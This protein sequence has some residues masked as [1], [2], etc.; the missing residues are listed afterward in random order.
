MVDSITL[1]AYLNQENMDL[2]ENVSMAEVN[3]S[4]WERERS[5]PCSRGILKA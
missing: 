3:T 1:S 2:N 5:T 4:N